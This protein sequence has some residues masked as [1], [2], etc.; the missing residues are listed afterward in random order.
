MSLYEHHHLKSL[1]AAAVVWRSSIALTLNSVVV[2]SLVE[3]D[4]GIPFTHLNDDGE[5]LIQGFDEKWYV[6]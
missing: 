3:W 2:L 6:E 1:Q 5:N 4:L